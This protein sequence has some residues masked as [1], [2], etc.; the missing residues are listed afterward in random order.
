MTRA[1]GIE[2]LPAVPRLRFIVALLLAT[3]WLPATLHCALEKAGLIAADAGDA[4]DGDHRATDDCATVEAGHYKV[5]DVSPGPAAPF[6]FAC[7]ELGEVFSPE[8][9]ILPRVSPERS[10]CPL[11]VPR[12]WHFLVRAALPA[13]A[14]SLVS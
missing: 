6:L 8:T 4:Q 11:E 1:R 2:F 14:P 13:R 10:D 9:I 5:S 3:L 7:F 12:T